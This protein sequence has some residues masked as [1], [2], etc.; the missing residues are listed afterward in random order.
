MCAVT[1]AVDAMGGDR[2]PGEIVAGAVQ[3]AH[4]GVRVLLCGARETVAA[5]LG[6]DAGSPLIEL[7]DAPDVIGFSDEPAS[8]VRARPQSSLVVAC[9]LVR[10]GRAGAALSAGSTGAMLAASLLHIGRIRRVHRPGIAVV[11]PAQ[12][13]PTVLIDAG[14]NPECRPEN[15]LQFGVMGSVFAERVLQLELPRVGL[16]SIGE[17]ATKGSALTLE[18]HALLRRAP[19]NFAGNCEGRDALRGEFRVVVADGFSGNVL[20]KGL[21][22]T[23]SVLFSEL[24]AAATS[25]LRAKAGALLLRPALRRVAEYHDPERIGGAYLLGVRGL[26][27]IAHGN[28]SRRAI[29]NAISLAARGIEAEVVRRMEE[30]LAAAPA[31]SDLQDGPEQHIVSSVVDPENGE[32]RT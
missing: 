14:A 5:A 3:A 1:V 13:G 20:L 22:G 27:I 6:D 18:S 26:S 9:R 11:L 32:K 25:S 8:A 31:G 19:V 17:E 16:L 15:L 4:Q 29:C 30:G 10:E 12:G 28:S 2:A 24:R 7:V 23:G 21:E